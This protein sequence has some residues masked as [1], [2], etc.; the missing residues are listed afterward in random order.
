MQPV[1][2]VFAIG[3]RSEIISAHRFDGIELLKWSHPKLWHCYN[4]NY[5]NLRVIYSEF[6]RK[7]KWKQL[8]S[9]GNNVINNIIEF[10]FFAPSV[11]RLTPPVPRSSGGLSAA[12]HWRAICKHAKTNGQKRKTLVRI[13][14]ELFRALC[15]AFAFGWSWTNRRFVSERSYQKLSSAVHNEN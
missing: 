13:A 2:N 10:A 9:N 6:T 1:L 12:F 4:S 15:S 14:S 5:F 3:K 8:L 11:T 7:Q